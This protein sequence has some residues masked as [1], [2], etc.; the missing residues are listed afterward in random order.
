MKYGIKIGNIKVDILL[1][2]DDIII[3]ASTINGMVEM[4]KKLECFGKENEIKFNVAKTFIMIIHPTKETKRNK[5][6]N[7]S[8]HV[9][10]NDINFKLD[11]V[12]IP[13][14]KCIRYLGVY[15]NNKL[16]NTDH[17]DN[18]INELA[19]KVNK[20]NGIGFSSYCLKPLTKSFYY[21]T[22]IRPY[23]LYGIE[24]FHF[25]KGEMKRIQTAEANIIKTALNLSYSLANSELLL[26]L[27]IEKSSY[28]IDMNK[29]SL[30]NGLTNNSYTKKIIHEII[31]EGKY[32]KINDSL[33]SEIFRITGSVN[34]NIEEIVKENNKK[35]NMMKNSFNDERENNEE[36]I[37]IC[38]FFKKLNFHREITDFLGCY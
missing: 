28:Q 35:L 25:N 14:V 17:L 12:T 11:N 36:V 8:H 13:V 23:L 6:R 30:F 18:K 16:T 27:N 31:E 37:E 24:H 19:T 22:Y 1:Y 4:L 33:I 7:F 5:R 34:M 32:Y 3:M 29:L 15:I 2:A 9:N 20:I 38:N 21:N 26:A 10:L